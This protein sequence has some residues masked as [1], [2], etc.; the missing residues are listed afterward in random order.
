M[1]IRKTSL[2]R[3]QKNR[4]WSAVRRHLAWMTLF[5]LGLRGGRGYVLLRYEWRAARRL[6]AAAERKLLGR[7]RRGHPK[8]G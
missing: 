4:R 1:R 3:S 5:G 6:R 8:T 7:G 2:R